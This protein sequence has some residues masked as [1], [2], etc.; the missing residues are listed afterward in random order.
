MSRSKRAGSGLIRGLSVA[1]AVLMVVGGLG[2][3]STAGGGSAATFAAVLV[4]VGANVWAAGRALRFL[5]A[6]A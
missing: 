6:E 1:L 5:F 2:L 3:W 4:L